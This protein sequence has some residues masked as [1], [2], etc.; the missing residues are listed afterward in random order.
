MPPGHIISTEKPVPPFH[1][2]IKAFPRPKKR[3]GGTNTNTAGAK[4]KVR[5]HAEKRHA[6]CVHSAQKCKFELWPQS[7]QLRTLPNATENAPMKREKYPVRFCKSVFY[8][9]IH[10]PCCRQYANKVTSDN[11]ILFLHCRSPGGTTGR[12]ALYYGCPP[13][14]SYCQTQNRPRRI[15]HAQSISTRWK[16]AW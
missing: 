7:E 15:S 4:Q 13:G 2:Q 9:A 12:A 11:I 8:V 10:D 14:E 1:A 6:D 5:R 3:S 16:S